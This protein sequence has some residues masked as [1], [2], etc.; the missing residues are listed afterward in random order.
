MDVFSELPIVIQKEI[1]KQYQNKNSN[2]NKNATSV[3][4]SLKPENE[5][6]AKNDK[7]IINIS[8]NVNTTIDQDDQD[9][10]ESNE[11]NPNEN[12]CM[13]SGMDIKQIKKIIHD[14]VTTENAP[15]L[16]DVKMLGEYFKQLALS[17]QISNLYKMLK[18]LYRC[19][20]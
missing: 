13:F 20:L 8:P 15:E 18:F 4:P 7:N 11:T 12:N 19:V 14:W 3:S 17:K 6:P 5:S 9:K 10:N 16:C 1:L 2:S